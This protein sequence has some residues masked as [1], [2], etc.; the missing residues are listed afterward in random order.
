MKYSLKVKLFFV[1]FL[2]SLIPLLLLEVIILVGMNNIDQNLNE[3]VSQIDTN[4]KDD[5]KIYFTGF[6]ENS[7]KHRSHDVSFTVKYYFQL[8]NV[9]PEKLNEDPALIDI[10][11]EKVGD[12]GYTAIFECKT[13]IIRVHPNSELIN[14]NLSFLKEQLPAFWT[15][16]DDAVKNCKEIDGYYKWIDPDGKIRDK[17]MALHPVE[18]TN[19]MIAT[20]TYIDDFT[21]PVDNLKTEISLGLGKTHDNLMKIKNRSSFLIVGVGIFLII[22][23]F[24]VTLFIVREM[25][26]PIIQLKLATNKIKDGE[27]DFVKVSSNDEIG[28][29]SNDFNEMVISMKKSKL[30]L[31][32]ANVVLEEKV[33][34]RTQELQEK[35]AELEKF[36]SLVIDRELKMIELKEKIKTF[37]N[38]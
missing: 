29:L 14:K 32:I 18:G 5:T 37:E 13:G 26:K 35:V 10:S 1:I 4:I 25:L 23:V 36:N 22:I 6:A 24:F 12:T 38:R 16:W 27:F 2:I 30:D 8:H 20:T 31:E 34:K 17:Y 21:K 33:E 28:D 15:I 7:L 11:A 19:Y 9:S 3:Y